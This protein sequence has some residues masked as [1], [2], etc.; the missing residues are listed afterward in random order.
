MIIM[1]N[2]WFMFLL[3]IP[4]MLQSCS[5]SDDTVD[6]GDLDDG[7]STVVR[8]LP[9]DTNGSMGGDVDGKTKQGFDT[10]LFRLSDQKQV[11]LRNEADSA[12]WMKTADWDL[13]FTGPY[14]SEVFVNNANYFYNPGYEGEAVNTS[15][16]MIDQPY[17]TVNEAPSDEEFDTSEITKIG[18]ATSAYDD[19]WFFYSMDTHIAIPVRDR[20]WAIRLPDGK[21]AKLE[22]ISV[23]QGNPPEVTNMN[24]PAPY[25][26]FRYYVQE[27][28]SEN[29]KT[30]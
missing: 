26:T 23:Y 29:L 24:W 6:G 5:G 12:R 11:W 4:W 16:V 2:R 8:D 10:F 20:T 13:A 18:W 14:N 21:Y 9:G 30:Q 7:F 19:G 25:F 15:V 27:D 28:G 22:L 3:L 17:E 1:V